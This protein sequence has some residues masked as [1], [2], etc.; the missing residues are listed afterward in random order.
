MSKTTKVVGKRCGACSACQQWCET[1]RTA[2]PCAK[3]VRAARP[4][5]A[6]SI[7]APGSTEVAP[8]TPEPRYVRFTLS[9]GEYIDVEMIRRDGVYGLSVR[10]SDS[11]DIKLNTSNTLWLMPA[12]RRS[13]P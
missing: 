12:R 3:L 13:T 11:L 2:P 5:V 4:F 10:G 7:A 8:L 1:P 9:D 6:V